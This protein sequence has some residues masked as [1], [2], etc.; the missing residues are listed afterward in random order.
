[1]GEHISSLR[2][3][4][5]TPRQRQRRK[6]ADVAYQRAVQHDEVTLS[7][8]KHHVRDLVTSIIR[9]SSLIRLKEDSGQR[10]W[11]DSVFDNEIVQGFIRGHV[12]KTRFIGSCTMEGIVTLT[13]AVPAESDTLCGLRIEKLSIPGRYEY[14]DVEGF[15]AILTQWIRYCRLGKLRVAKS[16]HDTIEVDSTNVRQF[17]MNLRSDSPRVIDVEGQAVNRDNEETFVRFSKD[18]ENLWM[19]HLILHSLA[20]I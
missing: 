11:Y 6:C 2:V 3:F 10:H 13:V 4:F 16:G 9:N 1:M 18:E 7:G 5:L 17:T 8:C 15:P 14:Y 19:V 20:A 12:E